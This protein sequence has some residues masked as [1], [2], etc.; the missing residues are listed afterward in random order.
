MQFVTPDK[1]SAAAAWDVVIIGSG[2]GSLF[3]LYKYLQNRPHDRVLI[4]EKGGYH[5]HEWQLQNQKNSE[6]DPLDTFRRGGEV[7]KPWDFTIGLGGSTNCWWG[8]TPRLHP[9]DFDL[10]TRLGFGA[11]W[12]IR[13]DDLVPY[14]QEAERIMLI[15]GSPELER[16][17]PGS[18]NYPQPPHR[19]TTADEMLVAAGDQHHFPMPTAKL[20]RSVS[21]RGRCCSSSS[22]NLCPVSAKFTGLN[23]MSDVLDHPSV[24][25]CINSEVHYIETAS[26][27][28]KSVQFQSRGRDYTVSCDLCVLGANA[29]HS[30]F[31]MLRSGISGH[32]VG[33]YLGEKML[34]SVEVMFDGLNHYD[35]GTDSTAFNIGIVEDGRSKDHSSA[36]MVV[37][38]GFKQGLRLEPGR[39]RENMGLIFYVEDVFDHDNGVFDDGGDKPLVKFKGYSDYAMAG[40]QNALDCLPKIL[41]PLPV[42]SIRFHRIEPTMGH[43]QGSLRMGRSIEESVVDH[44]LVSHA[45]RNLI[46]VGTSTFPTC[47]SANPSL[48]AAALSLRAAKNILA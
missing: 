13:Y 18:S 10:K 4:L 40:L 35:G 46:V 17:Y 45:I 36:V 23:S 29:I 27:V 34:A 2:F 33:R 24:S 28:A 3:F 26:G 31:I 25:I 48:T 5:N 44:N 16:S 6:I 47:G 41:A 38:N 22:C 11:D 32:G 15:A 21:S 42:E 14:W 20:S 9:T 12:P 39:W 37:Q 1:A 7:E 8:L 43:V 19:M 30:A